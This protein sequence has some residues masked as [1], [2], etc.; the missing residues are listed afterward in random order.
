MKKRWIWILLY[1]VYA[2]LLVA[3]LL[4]QWKTMGSAMLRLFANILVLLLACPV[5]LPAFA[6]HADSEERISKKDAISG[7][8]VVSEEKNAGGEQI[9]ESGGQIEGEIQDSQA[10]S[11]IKTMEDFCE[12]A[13]QWNFSAREQEVGW[14]I[15]KGY[16]NRQISQELYIAETTVKKHAGHIY[17]KAGVSGRKEFSALSRN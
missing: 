9:S 8:N 6:R 3:L 16:T 4:L 5:I 2:L 11:K 12:W 14:L 10:E 1:I 13:E 17:E 15:Y 7:K